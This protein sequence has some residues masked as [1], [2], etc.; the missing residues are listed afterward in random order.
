[1]TTQSE[2][3]RAIDMTEVFLYAVANG[4]YKMKDIRERAERLHRH[5]PTSKEID[6]FWE[7]N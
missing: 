4:G 6:L 3:R 7:E 1:M 5:F 2:R